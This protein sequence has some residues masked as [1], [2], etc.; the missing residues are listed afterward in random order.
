M[1]SLHIISDLHLGFNEKAEEEHNIPDVD[2]VIVNGNISSPKRAMLYL[3]TLCNKYPST[4][5]VYNTGYTER[6]HLA[7]E[8]FIGHRDISEKLRSLVYTKYPKNLHFPLNNN[9]VIDTRN[10]RQLDVLCVFGFPEIVKSMIDWETTWYHRHICMDVTRDY[11]HVSFKKP[12][13][14]SD[15][16]HGE[17]PIFA[18][19]EFINKQN[20]NETSLIRNWEVSSVHSKILVTHINPYNDERNYGLK[21]RPHLIH[22]DYSL[23]VTSNTKVSDVRFSGANLISNP[24]RGIEQRS[25]IIEF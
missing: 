21:V 10:G 11:K 18:S 7:K 16:S 20:E 19:M 15:V 13:E 12:A 8:K 5:F 3:E 17:I 9:I 24:G 4:Q 23:W 2:V 22:L 25:N 1:T 6:F 14:T